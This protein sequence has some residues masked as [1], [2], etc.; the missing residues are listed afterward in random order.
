MQAQCHNEPSSIRDDCYFV[1]DDVNDSTVRRMDESDSVRADLRRKQQAAMLRCNGASSSSRLC[2]TSIPFSCDEKTAI[3]IGMTR[4]MTTTTSS[5][6][7]P[8]AYHGVSTETTTVPEQHRASITNTIS[9]LS[10]DQLTEIGSLRATQKDREHYH[11]PNRGLV[12]YLPDNV[13]NIDDLQARMHGFNATVQAETPQGD[14]YEKALMERKQKFQKLRTKCSI[15]VGLLLLVLVIAVGIV[16]GSKR[17]N[18]S[19]PR[20]DVDVTN[21]S[22][23]ATTAMKPVDLFSN[24]CTVSSASDSNA[25]SARYMQ[26]RSEIATT[27]PS[28][29]PEI[30][31]PKSYQRL[32]LCWLADIDTISATDD[33]MLHQRFILTV[34]Y[35]QQVAT[36]STSIGDNFPNIV[37]WLISGVHECHWGLVECSDIPSNKV[38]SLRLSQLHLRGKIPSEISLL[39]DLTALDLSS[40]RLTGTIPSE[41]WS[42]TQLQDLSLNS[43][44]LT[45]SVPDDIND[46]QQLTRLDLVF[47]HFTGTF[48]DL[49]NLTR[50]AVLK[51]GYNDMFGTFPDILGSKELGERERERL[52][53]ARLKQ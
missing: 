21:N 35:F 6:T 15:L 7:I 3:A 34:I 12:R 49:R 48:P 1:D 8:G 37:D 4:A 22:T 24:P 51:V 11:Q 28:L 30:D 5:S 13:D 50:L 19:S 31:V 16:F 25:M 2:S 43:N 46:L 38:Q 52:C 42:M 29:A 14:E 40:N 39:T 9:K 44:D 20:N 27:Y 10:R 36:S 23:Q 53:C 33:T 41:L 47:N 18:S 32:A 26:L 17:T 45:G